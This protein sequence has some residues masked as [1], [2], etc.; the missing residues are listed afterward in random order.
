MRKQRGLW[1]A[2]TCLFVLV[3]LT[4]AADHDG[5]QVRIRARHRVRNRTG[6]QCVWAS[7]ECLARH[8]NIQPAMNLTSTYTGVSDPYRTIPVLNGLGVGYIMVI[9]GRQ[10]PDLLRDACAKGWG[11]AVGLSHRHVVT[12]IHYKDGV[13]KVID[14]LDP[15]LRV[16]DWSEQHFLARWDGWMIVLYK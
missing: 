8:H 6:V 7:L 1:A 11:A 3:P 12:V 15:E 10:R 13:V 5:A 2:V 14:N 16:Q 9:P 4:L